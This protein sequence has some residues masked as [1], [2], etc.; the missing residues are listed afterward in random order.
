[1]QCFFCG[2]SIMYKYTLNTSRVAQESVDSP[3]ETIVKFMVNDLAADTIFKVMVS[4]SHR[5]QSVEEFI[6]QLVYILFTDK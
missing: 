6:K 1:M 5:K 3:N 2:I 4:S